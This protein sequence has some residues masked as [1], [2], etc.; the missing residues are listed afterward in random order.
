MHP[1][2]C[3]ISATL[4]FSITLELSPGGWIK[5]ELPR[6]PEI[7]HL[8]TQKY[9]RELQNIKFEQSVDILAFPHLSKI[10]IINPHI[11]LFMW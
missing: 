1:D 6:A 3:E 10:Q 2:D 7:D 4:I 8:R 5:S 11:Y 9:L